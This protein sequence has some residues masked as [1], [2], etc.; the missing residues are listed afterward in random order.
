MKSKSAPAAAPRAQSPQ[1]RGERQGMAAETSEF[2]LALVGLINSF[3]RWVEHCGRAAGVG[4]LSST[5][6][7]VLHFIIYRK[8]PMTV[9]ALGFALSIQETHLVTYSV[10]KLVRLGMLKG[11]RVGKE[12]L[13]SPTK[14]SEAQYTR[15]VE[16]RQMHLI[17]AIEETHSLG[18]DMES[19]AVKLRALSGIYE[20]A[21]RSLAS[22]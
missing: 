4:D 19:L 2:E 1:S 13:F 16:V 5:D 8:R 11:K 9:S 22:A 20:Q 3:Y 21:A 17:R 18:P 12:V 15:Y 6:L 14:I 7:L 10:K